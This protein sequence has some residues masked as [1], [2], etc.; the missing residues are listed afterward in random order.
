MTFSD[1]WSTLTTV[2]VAGKVEKKNGL[3]YLSW[4]WAWGVLME[5]YPEATYEFQDD[6]WCSQTN[7]VEVICTVTIG[8]LSRSM[9][10]PVMDY[11]NKAIV[12]PTSRD[13][14]DSRMRCLV[15]CLAMFGLGHHIYAGEDVPEK[16]PEQSKQKAVQKPAK[17]ADSMQVK[18]LD[19]ADAVQINGE[20]AF[21]TR[22]SVH[23]WVEKTCNGLRLED[24][25]Q[26]GAEKLLAFLQK[27]KDA[28]QWDP[29]FKTPLDELR[30]AE[31]APF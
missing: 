17:L 15:K 5:H 26:S 21:P 30:T 18:I 31:G 2:D 3:A 29:K 13:I 6:H 9:W 24:L 25:T 22:G 16:K 10:L 19:A 7:T 28:V 8:G 27:N 1:I 23:A 20:S 11:R 4:A 12:N 14:S